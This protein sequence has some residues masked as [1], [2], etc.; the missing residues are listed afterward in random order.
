[1]Q[2]IT[3][4]IGMI[5]KC[6]LTL[7]ILS[8]V[9]FG[10]NSWK[11]PVDETKLNAKLQGG[12]LEGKAHVINDAAQLNNIDAKLLASI[13]GCESGFGKSKQARIKRNYCG[14]KINGKFHTFAD[15]ERCIYYTAELIKRR[16]H[17]VTIMAMCKKYA[18]NDPKWRKTVTT[19]YNS[20]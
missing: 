20:L 7:L 4:T 9:A 17:T 1:M 10:N 2:E 15:D 3:T 13:I 16:Y 14:I 6:I 11:G 8:G 18:Q 19:I 12:V 5:K